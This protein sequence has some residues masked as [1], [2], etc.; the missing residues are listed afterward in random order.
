[1]EKK[2]NNGEYRKISNQIRDPPSFNNNHNRYKSYYLPDP[3]MVMGYTTRNEN[4]EEKKGR[5][6]SI[7]T[8]G[9][10]GT[11]YRNRDKWKNRKR[12]EIKTRT[13]AWPGPGKRLE[14]R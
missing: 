7:E 13:G 9:G 3:K 1:M 14:N 4:H 12:Y 2:V 11:E 10:H 5:G 8:G 6:V